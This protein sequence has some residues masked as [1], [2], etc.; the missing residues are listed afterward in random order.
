MQQTS[1]ERSLQELGRLFLSNEH[2]KKVAAALVSEEI[3]WHF[4]PPRSPHFGGS[5]EAGV[6][7]IKHLE[8]ELCVGRSTLTSEEL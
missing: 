8:G 2:N 6:R 7:S 5:W 4:I 1:Q 3:E